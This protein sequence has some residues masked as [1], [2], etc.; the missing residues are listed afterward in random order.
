MAYCRYGLAVLGF[1]H[2]N[3]T[4]FLLSAIHVCREFYLMAIGS[5]SIISGERKQLT[6]K[7]E[8]DSIKR[9]KKRRDSVY[10]RR[11]DEPGPDRPG[12]ACG[13]RYPQLA[14]VFDWTLRPLA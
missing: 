10:S 14:G 3:S 11:G 1:N 13:V 4:V 5:R 7:K 8:Y 2:Q 9:Y 12:T 6:Q